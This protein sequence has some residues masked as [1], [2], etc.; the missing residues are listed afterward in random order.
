VLRVAGGRVLCATGYGPTVAAAAE[1]SRRLADAVSF[2]GK[3][4]RRD[5]GWREIAR[6]GAP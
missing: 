4:L 2:D 6:A 3:V 1:A 5:I